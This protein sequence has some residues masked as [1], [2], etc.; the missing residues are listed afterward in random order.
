MKKLQLT[1]LMLLASTLIFA[2]EQTV[3]G[4]VTSGSN[5]PMPGVNVLIKG[6]QQGTVTDVNG[7]YSLAVGGDVNV[8]VFSFIGY[9]AQEVEINNR[10]SIDVTLTEDVTSLE[11]VVVVGYGTQKKQNLTGAVAS[12]N[13]EEIQKR[14]ALNASSALQGMAAGVTVTQSTG[15]PGRDGG[16][17]R[18]RGISTLSNDD[19]EGENDPLVLVDGVVSSFDAVDPNNIESISILKDAAAASIYG[20]RA[21]SGVILITTKRAKANSFRLTY[22]G[23][24]GFQTPVDQP[25]YVGAVEYMQLLNEGRI[26]EGQSP[27]YTDQFIEEYAQNHAIN[28]DQYADTDWQDAVIK[29]SPVQQYHNIIASGGSEKIRSLASI[30]YMDQD[31]L[32]GLS[33][34]KRYSLRINNDLKVTDKIDLGVDLSLKQSERAAPVNNSLIWNSINRLPPIHAARF[35]NGLYAYGGGRNPLAYTTPDVGGQNRETSNYAMVNLKANYE[36]IEGLNFNVAF[37]PTLN[38]DFAKDFTRK[39]DYYDYG[40]D[41]P[42]GSDPQISSLDESFSRT[43]ET[44]FKAIATYEK[45]KESHYLKVLGGFDQTFFSYENFAAFRDGFSNPYFQELNS[46]SAARQTNEGTASEW[47]LRSFFG[48]VN[49]NFKEKYLFEA[50]IRYDGSSRFNSVSRWGVFPSGSAAWRISNE[51]FFAVPFIDDLKIR[52]SWGKLGNQNIGTYPFIASINLNQNAIFN[53]TPQSAASQI[54]QSNPD[55]SWETTSSYDIGIDVSFLQGK[56]QVEADYYVRNTSDILLQLPIPATQ[57]LTAP[58]QNAGLIKNQGWE[59][60]ID[61]FNSI[62][63]LKYS[64]GFKIWDVKNTV[65]DLKGA[66]PFISGYT[67]IE[68]G[69]EINALYGLQATGLFQNQAQVEEHATQFGAVMPGDI[70]YNNLSGDNVVNASDRAIIGSTIPRLEYSAN[71]NLGYKGFDFTLF[72]Q[73]VGKRNGYQAND[74]AWAFYNGGKA[75]LR[76]RD[77]WTPE[78]MDASYPRLFITSSLGSN[79]AQTSSYWVTD[80]SYLKVKNV[81]LGYTFPSALT[82]R[83]FS[84]ARVYIS[85]QNVISFDKMEG[86]DPEAPLGDSNF[87][88]QVAVYAMG[89][90]LTF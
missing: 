20:S 48:R 25:E 6:T 59:L 21:A 8:L 4:V 70:I 18:I 56:I 39:I 53:Q 73:G 62:G 7:R 89:V 24:V 88:P 86:F 15:E 65:L 83:V 45:V 77:R 75:Q 37:A 22:D 52:G 17:I 82:G 57:G 34:F 78:N 63:D 67:I 33:N 76:H 23:Y 46:G 14:S 84:R 50:N 27:L 68:E 30:G 64:I 41:V 13:A 72:F 58:F 1:L 85:G 49:Y 19:I 16:T 11:E 90:N 47:A 54:A 10:S 31:G 29:K 40:A 28:P 74:A 5:E 80:A 61:H 38:Q 81:V 51:P 43:F 42:R 35:S 3:T 55:I 32:T 2:Q 26:N 66:G 87:Y 44:Y 79:N 69:E 12:V 60:G 9:N 36:P 71:I